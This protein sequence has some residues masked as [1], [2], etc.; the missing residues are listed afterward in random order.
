MTAWG[1]KIMQWPLNA[2]VITIVALSTIVPWLAVRLVRRIWPYPALKENNELL[3][4]TYAVY[5]L[6]YGVLLAFT[7]V[8][9]GS[10]LRTQKSSFCMRRRS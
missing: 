3:G 1:H 10:V 5:G 2:S 7:I 8:V 4:F 6:I 9:A